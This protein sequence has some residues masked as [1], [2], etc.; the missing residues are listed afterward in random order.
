MGGGA[1]RGPGGPRRRPGRGRMS[2]CG[3]ASGSD[4]A[5]L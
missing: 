4:G 2:G 5:A 1:R 3:S